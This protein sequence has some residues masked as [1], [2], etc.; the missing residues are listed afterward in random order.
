M[1][2]GFAVG[3]LDGGANLFFGEI[4]LGKVVLAE[5][6]GLALWHTIFV[7]GEGKAQ[8]KIVAAAGGEAGALVFD[9]A[10]DALCHIVDICAV[11][12]CRG[13]AGGCGG[14]RRCCVMLHVVGV[15]AGVDVQGGGLGG[16]VYHLIVADAEDVL[17][18]LAFVI[19][20]HFECGLHIRP[21]LLP[22]AVVGLQ[23]AAVPQ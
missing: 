13:K 1:L 23:V 6:F 18:V 9:A 21:G 7:G 17:R 19:H 22:H 2:H 11:G 4:G 12:A 10:Y 8:H 15:Q 5:A 16:E 14:G 20:G 3:R